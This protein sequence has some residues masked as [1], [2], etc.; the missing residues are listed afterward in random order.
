[1]S[2][3]EHTTHTLYPSYISEFMVAE[4]FLYKGYT[5]NARKGGYRGKLPY[6]TSGTLNGDSFEVEFLGDRAIVKS[7]H[8]PAV[9]AMHDVLTEIIENLI[10]HAIKREA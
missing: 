8:K 5:P 7:R 2:G 3:L 1:M 6:A 10:K 4:I 9:D